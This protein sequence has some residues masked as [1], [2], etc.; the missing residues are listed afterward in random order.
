MATLEPHPQLAECR[1]D[2]AENQCETNAARTADGRYQRRK[3]GRRDKRP[4][5]NDIR[6]ARRMPGISRGCRLIV[7]TAP[8]VNCVAVEERYRRV[9]DEDRLHLGLRLPQGKPAIHLL[10]CDVAVDD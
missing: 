4:K 10:L 2:E 5:K 8:A 1:N 7:R 6:L 3:S 9:T